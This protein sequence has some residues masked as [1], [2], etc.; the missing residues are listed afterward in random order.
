MQRLPCWM[1]R[2]TVK[3]KSKMAWRGT[4]SIVSERRNRGRVKTKVD[5]LLECH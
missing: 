5:I 4:I 2:V 1:D 3:K